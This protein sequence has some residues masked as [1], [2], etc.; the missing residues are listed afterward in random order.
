[1]A[2]VLGTSTAP[3]LLDIQISIVRPANPKNQ[4]SK[5]YDTPSITFEGSSIPFVSFVGVEA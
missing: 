2:T 4:G 1:M 3:T 5:D